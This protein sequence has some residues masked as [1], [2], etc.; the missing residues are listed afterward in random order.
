EE[1]S[2]KI[3]LLTFPTLLGSKVDRSAMMGNHFR[4][5]KIEGYLLV[6]HDFNFIFTALELNVK[7]PCIS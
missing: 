1:G 7:L 2:P 6:L 3:L 5:A 4:A